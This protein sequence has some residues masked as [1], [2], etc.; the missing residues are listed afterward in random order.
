[1]RSAADRPLPVPAISAA[2]LDAEHSRLEATFATLLSDARRDDGPALRAQWCRFEHELLA[3]LKL[4]E[5]E[6]L[7]EFARPHPAEARDLR[8]EHARLR[9]GLLEL[10][11]ELDLHCLRADRVEAFVNLLRA[12]AR[13]EEALLYPWIATRGGES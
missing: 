7:P 3:H 1:M 8:D 4:E 2:H 11:V 12:H 5:R 9:A 6:I 13:R 10:G